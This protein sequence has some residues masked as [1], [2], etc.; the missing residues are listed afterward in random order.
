MQLFPDL[1][2]TYDSRVFIGQLLNQLTYFIP[3]IF[4]LKF[5][6]TS[7]NV[8]IIRLAHPITSIH[9]FISFE[10]EMKNNNNLKR[11]TLRL[12]SGKIF[13]NPVA[14]EPAFRVL[15]I[16][17]SPFT[18]PPR[19]SPEGI[20]PPEARTILVIAAAAVAVAGCRIQTVWTRFP[21]R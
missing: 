1:Q 16:I 2:T 7:I 8:Q 9:A 21:T 18:N 6:D 3:L 20:H 14:F 17:V 10:I 4:F 13:A 19:G 5:F 12:I 11:E 15:C